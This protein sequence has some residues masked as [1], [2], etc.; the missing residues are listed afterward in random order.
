MITL[1]DANNLLHRVHYAAGLSKLNVNFEDHDKEAEM[2]G[3]IY[4]FLRVLGAIFRKRLPNEYFVLVWDDRAKRKKELYPEYKAGRII[5]DDSLYRQ[6]DCFKEALNMLDIQHIQIEGEEADDVIATLA[7]KAR[8]AGHKVVIYSQDHDFEQMISDHITVR[9][10]SGTLKF[11]KDVKWVQDKYNIHPSLLG[12]VMQ[13]TG[14]PSDNVP[15]VPK[16]GPVTAI[17]L[18]KANG[19]LRVIFRDIPNAKTYD[20][21]G[22]LVQIS[23]SLA[24]KLEQFQNQVF[25]NKELVVLNTKVNVGE[26]EFTT[27][28][29]SKWNRFYLFCKKYNLKSILGETQELPDGTVLEYSNDFKKYQRLISYQTL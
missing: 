28:L 1:I 19:S 24:A 9:F 17:N 8:T 4:G 18:I 16:V 2:S 6:K 25:L 10:E 5:A 21:K 29:H 20:R 12:E 14:D 3:V 7:I 11:V 27:E 15:G 13:L 23:A 26:F 22:N